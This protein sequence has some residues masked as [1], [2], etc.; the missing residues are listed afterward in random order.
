MNKI[1]E[2]K[3]AGFS[4]VEMIV[5]ILIVAIMMFGVTAFISTSRVA[6]MK[7]TT[8]SKLQ[9]EA[10]AAV[11]FVNELLMEAQDYAWNTGSRSESIYSIDYDVLCIKTL[12]NDPGASATRAQK[13]VMY[14]Y[15]ILVDKADGTIRYCKKA[16]SV[17]DS[18][19]DA[20]KKLQFKTTDDGTTRYMVNLDKN[21][22]KIF[23]GVLDSAENRKY[24]YIAGKLDTAATGGP[25]AISH[26]VQKNGK[27]I[28]I[29]FTFKYNGETFKTTI[30]NLIRNKL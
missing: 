15:F 8:S 21:I 25:M 6:Y 24:S 10:D 11:K 19:T 13:L 9:E 22:D 27:K 4:L 5:S 29:V 2:N 1:K 7:V 12:D 17:I 14:Y 20:S 28:Q 3:N 26:S 23:A 30:N 16:A 18:E